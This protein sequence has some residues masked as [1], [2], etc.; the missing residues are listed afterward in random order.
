MQDLPVSRRRLNGVRVAGL[1][2]ILLLLT[3]ASCGAGGALGSERAGAEATSS[4]TRSS[5]WRATV[6][7]TV[8]LSGLPTITYDRLPAQARETIALIQ[9]GGP[10][11]YR[12]DG[13][14]FQNRERLLPGKPSGY[15]HEYTVV[16]PGSPDR[17]AR[18]IVTGANGELYYT[19]DHYDSFKQVIM[20]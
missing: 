8:A 17:G 19:N 3:L 7:P 10:F 11:P 6:T 5:T 12:Q 9:R 16:T 14:V 1:L 20:P 13:A 2:L 18:R 4:L 15:Y